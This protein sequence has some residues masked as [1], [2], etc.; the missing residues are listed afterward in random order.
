MAPRPAATQ[1]REA[2]R[3]RT[4]T[5]GPQCQE[6]AEKGSPVSAPRGCLTTTQ[7]GL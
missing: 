7:G 5:Q 1:G 6:A 3:P 4:T 2:R